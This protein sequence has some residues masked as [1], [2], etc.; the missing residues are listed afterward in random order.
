MDVSE[1]EE[2]GDGGRHD[3]RSGFLSWNPYLQDVN[4]VAHCQWMET[5][6]C[7]SVPLSGG[8]D[9][10][11]IPRHSS[12]GTLSAIGGGRILVPAREIRGW[13]APAVP[14]GVERI[15]RYHD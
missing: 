15:L 9:D 12:I 2:I 3:P 11:G 1:G 4:P 5:L 14:A 8:N 6:V 13:L 10:A 7:R